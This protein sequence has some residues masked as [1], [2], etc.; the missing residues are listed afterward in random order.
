MSTR[1]LL[2]SSAL[3]GLGLMLSLGFVAN[4]HE[5]ALADTSQQI[6]LAQTGRRQTTATDRFV[7]N[8]RE[9]IHQRHYE[10][11]IRECKA[12]LKRD[13]KYTP[14]ME[15]MARAYYQLGKT[16]FASA[17]CDIA[18]G[19][20]PNSGICYNLKGFV[21]L[22]QQDAPL[23]LQQFKK[24]TEANPEF[25]PAW[26]N[27][28]AR[29]LKAKN[30]R[31]A[32]SALERAVRLLPNRAAVHLNLGAAYRGEGKIVQAQQ[33]LKKALKLKPRYAKVYFNLGILYLDA[34]QFPGLDKI[35]QMQSAITNLNRYKQLRR[36]RIKD[37]PVDTYLAAAQREIER[38]QRRI[39]R[40]KRRKEREAARK[41]KKQ[42]E[43]AAAAKKAKET[44][45]KQPVADEKQPRTEKQAA[46]SKAK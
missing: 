33:A 19:I 32:T 15:V 11:A 40:E 22:K 42:A 45:A 16:E 34:Q 30:F 44:E 20:N 41:A 28:G 4:A 1:S 38:E 23:A 3:V 43:A 26:L 35:Q 2:T 31:D 39:K 13:E 6:L 17:I 5:G 18:L 10:D 21:A 29:L 37:D 36:R 9:K 24:A 8:A 27:Y 46:P 14:A 7:E 12:A 25:G